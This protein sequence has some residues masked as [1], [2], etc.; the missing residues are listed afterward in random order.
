M[1]LLQVQALPI[2]RRCTAEAAEEAGLDKRVTVS[3][4]PGV[5]SGCLKHGPAGLLLGEPFYCACEQQPPWA[6]LMCGA[7][8]HSVI[9]CPATVDVRCCR[10]SSNFSKVRTLTTG[11][12][13]LDSRQFAGQYSILLYNFGLLPYKGTN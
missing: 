12:I 5:A 10:V 13:L 4:M 9:S 1:Y 3:D 11:S 7:R 8:F 2:A 6:H